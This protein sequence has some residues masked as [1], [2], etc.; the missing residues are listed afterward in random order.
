MKLRL[1]I[2]TYF[3]LLLCSALL[4]S[5]DV[6]KKI[7]RKKEKQQL[8]ET[9]ETKTSSRQQLTDD[10]SRIHTAL[11]HRNGQLWI[12]FDG[13]AQIDLTPSGLRV[14]GYNPVIHG[15]VE[16][17]GKDSTKEQGSR[18]LLIEQ[19]SAVREERQSQ[20]ETQEFKKE[21]EQKSQK[22]APILVLGLL[23]V[24]ALIYGVKQF[25]LF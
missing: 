25:K 20:Q 2:L 3:L 1:L 16:S 15:Q 12:E 5:C 4:T 23:L 24:I 11:F 8:N 6:T 14:I 7:F 9:I 18:V 17:F 13:I 19:D 21:K 10:W 22:I